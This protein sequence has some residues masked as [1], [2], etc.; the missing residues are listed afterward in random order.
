[1]PSTL[2]WN[3]IGVLLFL[4]AL[5]AP[6]M[7]PLASLP[8]AL[9][10]AWSVAPALRARVDK[11]FAGLPARALIALLTYLGPLVRGLQRYLWRL[12]GHGDVEPV[13]FEGQ[14]QPARIDWLA[15]A[16]T[17]G[18]WSEQGHEKE[19]LLAGVME[20]LIPRKYLI[21]V[22]PG[23]NRWDLE[24][25]RGI[26]TKARLTVASENHGGLRRPLDARRQARR[27]RVPRL[28]PPGSPIACA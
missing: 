12:R 4:A 8:L 5:V 22:D 23:W 19:A 21:A 18:Y 25:Y 14:Q 15:R 6:R 2:E 26:W 17:L 1:L 27:A 9:S 28:G 20:F 3:A 13:E 24:L 16:F 11:R 10:F 7:L